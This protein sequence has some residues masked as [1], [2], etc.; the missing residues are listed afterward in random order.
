MGTVEEISPGL[1]RSGIEGLD[2]GLFS[3]H[4]HHVN[5][6]GRP[7]LTPIPLNLKSLSPSSQ[8]D[9]RPPESRPYLQI[10]QKDT[11]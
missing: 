11:I 7:E 5:V 9:S 1:E 4:T 6:D 10:R 3:V 8:T 2:R